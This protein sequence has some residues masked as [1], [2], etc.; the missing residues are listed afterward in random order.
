VPFT[1][2]ALQ[3]EANSRLGYSAKT[4]MSA[5]QG[6]YQAGL[7]TYHRTDSLNLSSEAIAAISNYIKQAFGENYV[8]VRRFHTKDAS[9]QE[10]H[11]AIRPTNI[12]QEVA[13]KN[14]YEKKL[15][16]L[17]RTRTLATQMKNAVVAKTTVDITPSTDPELHFTAKGE[18]A[19]TALKAIG[20]AINEGLGEG[21][22]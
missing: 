17:I 19:E 6:L 2:A 3:I 5:A 22:A 14:D 18:D 12:A 1:T 13:G 4:T 7:I 15:Y 9:A 8:Q 20:T 16:Q 21:A 11:E 10:A